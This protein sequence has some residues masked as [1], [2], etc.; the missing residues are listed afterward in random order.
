MAGFRDVVKLQEG[1]K[2]IL[3][4]NRAFALGVIHAGIAYADGYPGTPSSEVIDTL[5]QVPESIQANWSVNEAVGLGCAVGY[6][7]AGKDALVTMKVPG[8]FQAA[9]VLVSSAF[10]EMF[11]GALILYV[12]TDNEPSSSQYVVD[13]RPLLH[14]IQVPFIEPRNHQELYEAPRVA[15]QISRAEKCPVVILTSSILA[16]A[17]S[18]IKIGNPQSAS[19]SPEFN[20]KNIT[21]IPLPPFARKVY[22]KAV[23]SR[24]KNAATAHIELKPTIFEGKEDWGILCVGYTHSLALDVLNALEAKPFFMSVSVSNPLPMHDIANYRKKFSGK[25]YLLEEGGTFVENQLKLSGIDVIGKFMNPTITH[26]TTQSIYSFL[27]LE[28]A[29]IPNIEIKSDITVFRPPS[30]C[31][32]CP[33]RGTAAAIQQFKKSGAISKVFGDIGCSSLLS[34]EG[35]F[36]Y[37]LCMGA[38]DSMRQ[39]YVQAKPQEAARVL[40]LIGDSSECHSGMDAS[41]NSVYKNI[42]GIKIILDNSSV[43]MTGF[44]DSPTSGKEKGISLKAALEGENIPTVEVD[45]YNLAEI[46]TVLKSSLKKAEEGIFSAIVIKGSCLHIAPKR[47]GQQILLNKEK[48]TKC[49]ICSVCPHIDSDNGYYPHIGTD[50]S[51]CGSG[52]PLC[53][54]S[55]PKKALSITEK[56][57]VRL[58]QRDTSTKSE[59]IIPTFDKESFDG[60]FRLGICGV[61]GQGNLFIGKVL[62]RVVQRYFSNYGTIVKGEVHGMAQMGG[63]VTSTF[64]FGDVHSPLSMKQGMDILVS[65]ERTEVFRNNILENLKPEGKIILN[66]RAVLP[67]GFNKNEYPSLERVLDN[68]N[69]FNVS[70]I[71]IAEPYTIAENVFML[72]TLST[73]YPF[74]NIPSELWKSVLS[75]LSRNQEQAEFNIETFVAGREYQAVPE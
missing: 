28:G 72:G 29:E 47:K 53:I 51:L 63:P 16:H 60:I 49:G 66:E 18:E 22:D 17:E 70:L 3:M 6:A 9:D 15:A 8:L 61:G 34:F 20:G 31:V 55:C 40:S 64:S 74:T 1:E 65:L 27:K 48:C 35:V 46:K 52:T 50:C 12:A 71:R 32:G 44:Q 21:I 68:L 30:I 57:S 33:Y 5:I 75:S 58:K 10:A 59:I 42:P 23:T 73:M 62:A 14:S 4:G 7:T 2:T 25:L 37:S 56:G 19:I 39:G 24:M 11:S 41:R 38:S 26:W 45:A 13:V 36:D 54:Q 43:A 69:T 67:R